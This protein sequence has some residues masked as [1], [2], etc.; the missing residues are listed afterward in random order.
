VFIHVCM[1][2]GGPETG[3]GTATF[4]DLL[5]FRVFIHSRSLSENCSNNDELQINL[6]PIISGSETRLA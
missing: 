3:S 5:C 1:Y 6:Q 4:N 2:K